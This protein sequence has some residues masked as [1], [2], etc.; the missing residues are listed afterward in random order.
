MKKKIKALFIDTNELQ[1]KHI[2]TQEEK[3][4]RKTWK[5]RWGVVISIKA[6]SNSNGVEIS[7]KSLTYKMENKQ[8][9]SQRK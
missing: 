4:N 5:G 2:H 8:F 1:N 9:Y 6:V 7:G 3:F